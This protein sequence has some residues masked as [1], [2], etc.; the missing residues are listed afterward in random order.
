MCTD[1]LGQEN[2]RPQIERNSVVGIWTPAR[3][4]EF[5]RTRHEIR[6]E[7]GLREHA[8]THTALLANIPQPFNHDYYQCLP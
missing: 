3:H 7:I 5:A 6:L 2:V 1:A 4:A 8:H